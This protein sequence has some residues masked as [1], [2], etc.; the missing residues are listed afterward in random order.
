MTGVAQPVAALAALDSLALVA[1]A[2]ADA[3]AEAEAPWHD[4]VAI[5]V[6]P[7]PLATATLVEPALELEPLE[8][9]A[10]APALELELPAALA[11]LLAPTTAAA[12]EPDEELVLELLWPDAAEELDP[13]PLA[14]AEPPSLATTATT[15]PDELELELDEATTTPRRLNRTVK[16]TKRVTITYFIESP[17]H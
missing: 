5:V 15:E 1:L 3:A 13:E 12:V 7:L 10:L 14:A 16:P 6:L 11:P 9:P 8:E 4:C 2:A 17:F